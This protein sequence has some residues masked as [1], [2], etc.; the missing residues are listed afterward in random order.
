[1]ADPLRVY[2]IDDH[3]EVRRALVEQLKAAPEMQVVGEA[4][5]GET[6][7][8]E[9]QALQP[10]VVILETKRADGRGLE[11]AH[12]LTHGPLRA[13]IVVLT[14]YPSEWERW[15]AHRAG[16]DCYLLKEIGSP[17]LIREIRAAATSRGTISD[18][19]G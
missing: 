4:G 5:D 17:K 2:V 11:I 18:F 6:A 1:M 3:T 10:N 19:A 13:A 16:A 12:S 8:R 9:V 14:S 15:A 7:L